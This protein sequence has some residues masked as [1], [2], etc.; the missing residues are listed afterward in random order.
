MKKIYV[1]AVLAVSGIIGAA[2]FNVSI[3]SQ[4]SDNLSA[5]SLANIQAITDECG[6]VGYIICRCTHC[7]DVNPCTKTCTVEN[8]SRMC[9]N[10][11]GSGSVNCQSYN[12][13]CQ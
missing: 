4:K 2:M 5:V 6:C 11:H 1:L 9:A 12:S 13:N 3:N 8:N 7:G 10:D